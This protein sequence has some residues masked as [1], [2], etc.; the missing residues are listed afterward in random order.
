MCQEI[1]PLGFTSLLSWIPFLL[2]YSYPKEENKQ[3]NFVFLTLAYLLYRS[4]YASIA[5]FFVKYSKVLLADLQSILFS[6]E[7][8]W[9]CLLRRRKEPKLPIF[10]CI[11]FWWNQRAVMHCLWGK[12]IQEI[13]KLG[14]NYK[15]L[16]LTK[17]LCEFVATSPKALYEDCAACYAYLK[18]W[19]Q[20]Q[21]AE[22]KTQT[23]LRF[24]KAAIFSSK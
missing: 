11:H 2:I 6:I 8:T 14:Q 19:I 20:I 15:K 13:L 4:F 18:I 24:C 16:I 17:W 12:K 7:V 9:D 10:F 1:L 22:Y 3:E 21:F 5:L 23:K